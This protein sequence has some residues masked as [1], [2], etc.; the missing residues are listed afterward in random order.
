MKSALWKLLNLQ[1]N[2]AILEFIW[3]SPF[4]NLK[5]ALR[6]SRS[7]KETFSFQNNSKVQ[8]NNFCENWKWKLKL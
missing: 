2:T 7:A 4:D 8:F 6:Y 5:N 3:N 1:I